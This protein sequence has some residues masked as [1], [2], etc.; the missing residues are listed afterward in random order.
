MVM[1]GVFTWKIR[2]MQMHEKLHPITE[3]LGNGKK[4]FFRLRV[5]VIT[6]QAVCRMND[7]NTDK[8]LRIQWLISFH[9]SK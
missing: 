1:T 5:T 4:H 7:H 9:S 8:C 3:I 2:T 6:K